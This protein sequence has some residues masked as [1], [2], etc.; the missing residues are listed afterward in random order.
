MTVVDASVWVSR[1]V[2]GDVN[3]AAS[4]QWLEAYE[5]QGGRLVAPVIL[6]AE[7]AGA[8]SR[9][10]N[11]PRLGH[12]AAQ[13]LQRIRALRLVAVDRRLGE[14]AARLGADLGL[15]GADAVYV[16]LAQHLKMPL[17]TLD[18]E[19]QERAGRLVVTQVP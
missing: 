5:A 3:H 16:G 13:A 8:I 11:N 9:R 12:E 17:V 7:V 4:R 1:L 2:A 14:T 18:K 10:T 15:R 19:Q 6:L